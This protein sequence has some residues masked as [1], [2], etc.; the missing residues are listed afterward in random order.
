MQILAD[1][2]SE[3]E[4]SAFRK[5]L[6]VPEHKNGHA[7]NQMMNR[8]FIN[9]NEHSFPKDNQAAELKRVYDQFVQPWVE[10]NSLTFPKIYLKHMT[11]ESKPVISPVENPKGI[12]DIDI[13]LLSLLQ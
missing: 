3:E 2:L 9:K 10:R 1:G 8:L 13:P 4:K 11:E 7:Y 5:W 12:K 6:R